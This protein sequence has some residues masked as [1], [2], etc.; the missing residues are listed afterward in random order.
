MKVFN[1]CEISFV[2]QCHD[3]VNFTTTQRCTRALSHESR[4]VQIFVRSIYVD[5]TYR[6]HVHTDTVLTR[7]IILPFIVLENFFTG[8][9]TCPTSPLVTA[10]VPS[11]VFP[12]M[13]NSS[14]GRGSAPCAPTTMADPEILKKGGGGRQCISPVVI[15][16]KCTQLTKLYVFLIFG[17]RRL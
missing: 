7:G 13:F 2:K 4:T 3:R 10:D 17:E 9:S 14:D 11:G 1:T 6:C 15:Y 8:P 16:H 5:I 12:L